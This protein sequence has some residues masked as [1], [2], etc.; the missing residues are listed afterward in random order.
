MAREGGNNEPLGGREFP[1]SR[2]VAAEG[3][4]PGEEMWEEYLSGPDTHPDP[5]TWRTR[6]V[7]PVTP[8]KVTPSGP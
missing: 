6:V 3:L 2:G 4:V 1:L 8:G 7:V 5:G